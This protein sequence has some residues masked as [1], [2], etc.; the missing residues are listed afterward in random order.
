MDNKKANKFKAQIAINGK[1]KFL[2]YLVNEEDAR[3]AYLDAK[4]IYH[5]F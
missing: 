3:K 2:G 4:E 5:I 1:N